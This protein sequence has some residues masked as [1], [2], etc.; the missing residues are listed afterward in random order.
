ML[1][2]DNVSGDALFNFPA[3]QTVNAWSG[4]GS[5]FL[6]SFEHVGNLS[7]GAYFLPGVPLAG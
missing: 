1:Y 2:G 5:A 3:Y 7:K 4:G 6:Y